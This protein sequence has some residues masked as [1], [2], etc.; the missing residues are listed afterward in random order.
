MKRNVLNY[1][2]RGSENIPNNKNMTAGEMKEIYDRATTSG[3]SIEDAF[4]NVIEEAFY[5]GYEV[6]RECSK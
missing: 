4:F 5:F 6:G 2:K 3:A 1:A